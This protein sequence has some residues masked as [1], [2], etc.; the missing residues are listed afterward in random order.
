[1]R[2]QFR[3]TGGG[4]GFRHLRAKS[5][6]YA[7]VALR[8]PQGAFSWSFGPIH[9]VAPAGAVRGGFLFR[10]EKE[11]MA[12]A[13]LSWPFGPIHLEDAGGR[14]RMSAPRSYSPFPQTPF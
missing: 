8:T 10:V 13:T 1:M 6:R 5:R 4:A 2:G 3:R 11:P 7:A 9:L 12:Q 14:L